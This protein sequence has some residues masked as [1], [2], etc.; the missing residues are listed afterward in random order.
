M[1]LLFRIY[2]KIVKKKCASGIERFMTHARVLRV[3]GG[4]SG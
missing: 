3:G 1:R 2:K 4:C